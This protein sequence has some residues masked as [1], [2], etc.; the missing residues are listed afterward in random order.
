[1]E[2]F[3]TSISERNNFA[4]QTYSRYSNKHN[5]HSDNVRNDRKVYDIMQ[6]NGKSIPIKTQLHFQIMFEK[7]C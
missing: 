3:G 4:F 6:A 5:R 7:D 1:M 2:L